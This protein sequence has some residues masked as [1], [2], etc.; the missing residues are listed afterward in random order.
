MFQVAEENS[1]FQCESI[2]SQGNILKPFVQNVIYQQSAK[3]GKNY[4]N[5]CYEPIDLHTYMTHSWTSSLSPSDNVA[6]IF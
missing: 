2:L 3:T 1:F 6:V 4:V 5:Y